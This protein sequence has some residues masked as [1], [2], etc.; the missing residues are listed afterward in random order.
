MSMVDE[1]IPGL[2]QFV[3]SIQNKS[4]ADL[5]SYTFFGYT[6]TLDLTQYD[7]PWHYLKSFSQVLIMIMFAVGTYNLVAHVFG[8]VKLSGIFDSPTDSDGFE[9]YSTL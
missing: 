3:N 1:R 2:T 4:N 5:P 9:Y 8:F 6:F 7:L